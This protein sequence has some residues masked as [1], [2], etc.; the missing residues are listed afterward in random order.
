MKKNLLLFALMSMS[1]LTWSQIPTYKWVSGSQTS[2]ARSS[3]ILSGPGP[4][5]GAST[6]QDSQGN[7]WVFGGF[8]S[9]LT[10]TEGYYDDLW[11][12]DQTTSTWVWESG[13]MVTDKEVP[14][15]NNSLSFD[16]INDMVV[17]D[18]NPVDY[19]GSFTV[20][21]W[22][23]T[24]QNGTLIS[25]SPFVVTNNAGWNIA[26]QNDNQ[27]RINKFYDQEIGTFNT[28]T[29][30]D[31]Q[32]HH[33]ALAKVPEDENFISS[34]LSQREAF[35]VYVDGESIGS[36]EFGFSDDQDPDDNHTTIIGA[37]TTDYDTVFFKG[38]IDEVRFWDRVLSAGEIK[39]LHTIQ[40]SGNE[41]GLV[42][43]YPFNQGVANSASNNDNVLF[44]IQSDIDGNLSQDI[45]R[46]GVF[47]GE[48]TDVR[49][50]STALSE[51]EIKNYA[52]TTVVGSETNL[53]L[54]Y[55]FNVGTAGGDNTTETELPDLTGTNNGFYNNFDLQGEISNLSEDTLTVT[56]SIVL[57]ENNARAVVSADLNGDT[58][59]DVVTANYNP[60]SINVFINDLSGD[61]NTPTQHDVGS[62]AKE[63]A[64]GDLN[65]DTYDDLA[66]AAFGVTT[67]D[68]RVRLFFSD[69]LG[70]FSS[71]T[72]LSF[73][74]GSEPSE[75]RIADVNNDTFQ[76][77]VVLLVGE[78]R[79]EIHYGD[80]LG[81]F[82]T[83]YSFD[84]IGDH[85]NEGLLIEDFTND[86]YLDIATT[87]LLDGCNEIGF[88]ENDQTGEFSAGTFF[89]L[90]GCLGIREML[91]TDFNND[92]HKDIIFYDGN[93]IGSIFG[94][95]DGTF[96]E[97]DQ[98]FQ[99]F[100]DYYVSGFTLSDVNGDD[101][102]DIIINTDNQLIIFQGSN[103]GT[104][105]E[106][107]KLNINYASDD[108]ITTDIDKNGIADFVVCHD[109]DRI[110]LI[111]RETDYFNRA[112]NSRTI[113]F[114]GEDD[115]LVIPNLKIFD[116]NFTWEG[117]IKTEDNGPLFSFANQDETLSWGPGMFSLAIKYNRLAFMV[118]GFPDIQSHEEYNLT[119]G[120]WHH[121]AIVVELYTG[122]GEN[123][124]VRFFIDGIDVGV[125]FDYDFHAAIDNANGSFY[126]K[127]GYASNYFKNQ[128]DQIGIAPE[129]NWVEGVEFPENN[130][131]R[132]YAA[133]WSDENNLYV[134][135]GRGVDGIYNTLRSRSI[136]I[137][138][139][140]SVSGSSYTYFTTN[141]T[142][143][144]EET[145]GSGT[146]SG[147][148]ESGYSFNDASFGLY[149]L[150]YDVGDVTGPLLENFCTNP[151]FNGTDQFNFDF[152]LESPI[153]RSADSTAITFT[154]LSTL[155]VGGTTTITLDEGHWPKI[156]TASK[157][158][159][160]LSGS[161]TPNDPGNYGTL[162]VQDP[163]NS[164]PARYAMNG[165]V[166]SD[167]YVWIFG[168]AANIAPTEWYNDLWR[169]DPATN[170][171]MWVSGSSTTNSSAT[172]GSIGVGSTGNIPG[173]RSNHNIWTDSDG[174]IWIF[175]GYGFD[176]DGSIG[177]L[178]D[179]WKFDPQ[180][181]E[182]TWVNGDD[183][184]DAGGVY[185]TLDVYN[186]AN[187]PGARS[188][189]LQ[190]V[191]S[192]G[193]VWLFG[194]DGFDKFGIANNY[195]NDLWSYNPSL[196]QWAWHSGSD[197]A[198]STGSYNETGLASKDY[199]PGA[200][201]H[202]GGWVDQ[203]NDLWLF[204]GYKYNQLSTG[205]Y[206]DFWKYE[207]ESKEWTWISGY[208]TTA[209][210]NQFGVYDEEETGSK[211]HPGSRHGGLAWSDYEGNFWLLGGAEVGGTGN[212][213][214]NDLWKYEPKKD[215]W[216]YIKGST[217]LI[218]N[219]GVYGSK[220]IA[221]E[222]NDPKSRWHGASWTA[223][224]GKLWFFGGINHNPE[225][226]NIAWL[227]DLWYFDPST[228]AY[229]WIG[230][231]TTI[232]VAGV[233]GE[234]GDPSISHIPGARSS[235]AYWSDEEG[236]FWLFG[237]YESFEYNNDLWKFNPNTLEWTW[238]NGNN[239]QNSPSIYGELG[240]PDPNNSIGA[241]RYTDGRIDQEGNVW[242]FGGDGHDGQ[243]QRGLLND[244]WKYDPSTNIWT[245]MG[246]NT[247]RN[248]LGNYGTKYVAHP[249]NLPPPR[250]SHSSWIDDSGNLW[251]F[252]GYGDID[253]D[254]PIARGN[255]N[256]LW[257]YDVKTNL[258]TWM[259][260][261]DQIGDAGSFGAQGNFYETSVIPAKA[262]ALS[263]A[264]TDKSFWIFGGRNGPS[265]NDFWEIKFTPGLP[266][267]ES[268]QNI[269][270]DGFSFMSDEAWTREYQVQVDLNDDFSDPL[271]DGTSSNPES[272]IDALDPGTYY[273]YRVNAINEIGNSG[274]TDPLSILTL[275]ATPTFYSLDSAI[276]DLTSTQVS[277]D[278][279][280]TD[281]I[282]D[283][284]YLDV[285]QDPTFS[286]ATL[287][288][289][290]FDNKMIE[291]SQNQAIIDLNPGTK[292][293][294]RL[295]SYN[296]SGVSPYSQV[297]PFLTRP[298]APS[299]DPELV[300]SEVTQSSALVTWNEVPEIL[301]GYRITVSTLDDGLSDPNGYLPLYSNLN[302]A[303]TKTSLSV[304]G[305]N[306]G[307]NYYAYLVAINESGS[308]ELSGK[309][310]ILTTPASPVF[311]LETAINSITQNEITFNWESPDGF[312]N[313][314]YL[315]VS[316]DPSFVNTNLMLAGY[317]KGGIPFELIQSE[318][319]TTVGGL[320]PGQ[321]YFARIRA[322]ND[323][324]ISPNSNTLAF[325]TVPK[326]PI[327]GQV[328]NI[329]QTEASINWQSTV[330]TDVYL[331]DLNTS[332]AFSEDSAVFF[333][334]PLAVAFQVLDEL[335]PGTRYYL[336]VQSSNASGNS[337]D[338]D[339][340]DYGQ[341]NFITIPGTPDLSDV[342]YDQNQVIINWPDIEG[343]AT[344]E[345]DASNNFFLSFLTGFEAQS[346]TESEI[347]IDGLDAGEEYQV[348]VRAVNESGNSPNAQILDLLTLPGTP[349][350]RDASNSSSRVFTAN[351][352]AASG[353]DH[354]ILEVSVDDF[355]SFHYNEQLSAAN[356]IKVE[357]LT[358]G[359]T[360][361]Y[362]V[363]AGN[364]SGESP[365][366]E[367]ITVVAQNTAQSLSISSL[368]FNDEFG[369]QS[370][371]ALVTITFSGGAAEP[372]VTL[373][374]KETLSTRWSDWLPMERVS[375][376]EFTFTILPN[377]LDEIGV[378]FDI[379]ADDEVTLI[380]S[381]N[382]TIKRTF[383]E[384]ESE[385]LPELELGQWS[386]ISIPYILEDNL[387]QSIFNELGDL[388]YKKRWR[389]M[390]YL[391][392][393]YQDQGVG[394]TRID[395]G[396]GYWFNSLNEVSISVGAGQTN[397]TIPFE[398]SLIQGWNQIG[399][400]YNVTIDWDEVLDEN[401]LPVS[402]SRLI[403][404]D[405]SDKEFKESRTL[406]PFSGAFVF[407]DLDAV[408]DVSPIAG[409]TN[410]RI[411]QYEY[412]SAFEGQNWIKSLTLNWNGKS[413]EIAA[414][415]MHNQADH[416]KDP[417]D[418]LIVPRFEEYLEMYSLVDSY[419]Y[420]KFSHD[421]KPHSSEHVWVYDLESNH[422]SGLTELSWNPEIN[423][424]GYL[425]L[426]DETNGK[427][428]EMT[429][430]GSYSFGMNSSH[431]FS[432]H[433]SEDPGYVV[434][435]T[436][437]GL[438]DIYP[439]PVNNTA[440]ITL[441][442]PKH[443]E[444]Y[445]LSINL[446]NLNG[447][448]IKTLASGKYEPGIHVFELDIEE[449]NLKD[450]MYFYGVTFQ[451]MDFT[452]NQKKIIIKR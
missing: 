424:A 135:G 354:Y 91:S 306:Q 319:T 273:Y 25:F 6:F 309:I 366:S 420:P 297:V 58:Y 272:I 191:D 109:W 244:L 193:I 323:A 380:E 411:E 257:K 359:E 349:T 51:N 32:W 318:L 431:K 422:V 268:P 112:S 249:D 178:N 65:G 449:I 313:G 418:K 95:G 11:K 226:G 423:N 44:D 29:L 143:G 80:G 289:E 452:T 141:S 158:W 153:T 342:I 8:G 429:N 218:L 138:E 31:N 108:I 397:S 439:N 78:D 345:I 128:L 206:N 97:L 344:Y 238:V 407:A 188:A 147:S 194:G 61:L 171:W 66:V 361:K 401:N 404:Y 170:E 265:F 219:D 402:I 200:R 176:S 99:E 386:I 414:I 327:L 350:A 164:P 322:F 248:S 17:L 16:G 394:F 101:V 129:S 214:Y 27:I 360:Y 90:V 290:D 353:A 85:Y 88:H 28:N 328:N 279:E 227:N 190:W 75:V 251:I 243:S 180:T 413:K 39:S 379:Q 390:T 197:F 168:G 181:L 110:T 18:D 64:A 130:I 136:K 117:W 256:D 237:G 403:I 70:G 35:F 441:L 357:N 378:V 280:V 339:P 262:R 246:G 40:L 305:L 392:G 192:D 5:N 358:A 330:G 33:V 338:M 375:A 335:T 132:A 121:V 84:L 68:E 211:P 19:F 183:L 42:S 303:K 113:N 149:D 336:R 316:T 442:L 298:E 352:D 215:A 199:V 369:E 60:Q 395:L 36:E 254:G 172:Y 416:E 444:V 201:W 137:I 100:I 210:R 409:L 14:S 250:Y 67:G 343:A 98:V 440:Q 412:A 363:K 278:W 73:P 239:F 332:S 320:L 150:Y 13:K 160:I 155:G 355:Q 428:I 213:F 346:T 235:S 388:Q 127:L 204:G 50:W 103:D 287:I 144:P 299:F 334:F 377:M 242:V 310:N 348:R 34:S 245:W 408:V 427:I 224:D 77:I 285:S 315:E 148:P 15:Y 184:V 340:P 312:F 329:S 302:I 252:G 23:K 259:G 207:P 10:E 205:Y 325:T 89:P 24:D 221:S 54:A 307:T 255:M 434:I 189:G 151:T 203:N 4:R 430:V 72:D 276:N 275:P 69:G 59:P 175:G 79:I 351:W 229:T 134:F 241:R 283:G 22:F 295:Q 119:N 406:A 373:R 86:G 389:L 162:N 301:T 131:G 293:Y 177:H 7:Y 274:F 94:N 367:E 341:G 179:L 253:G 231:S 74:L 152:S 114:D 106:S 125:F 157:N 182:W 87:V 247:T 393:Q 57:S 198:G 56:P 236:N 83:S 374:H 173:P 426:V 261:S 163:T 269:R 111:K 368:E 45:Y 159:E 47:I 324:G 139:C 292:Y 333:N 300:V 286:D 126:A 107:S 202:S 133:E 337:G 2:R 266:F 225:I 433:Y 294:A 140:P 281:G 435:P 385:T 81:A 62:Y 282:L 187:I 71:T 331:M 438:G 232:D 102:D 308:S 398:M 304:T 38:Q 82:P 167:G 405:P 1:F 122:V 446:Y 9:D 55:D 432:I 311:N 362:R 270:Q 217:D 372:I 208:G 185:G 30:T 186:D 161:E 105:V 296:A 419:F 234:K 124:G 196:N 48:M 347:V 314:Y 421:I 326:A 288:H 3:L 317:G 43:Y 284:Y 63:L 53:D 145:N 166:D 443:N 174:Y 46:P 240:V 21:L 233:Y 365:Y 400:P 96:G 271:Y 291:V 52:K 92:G 384:T 370:T 445:D 222:L 49:V 223:Q 104:F 93:T 382:N 120:E 321:T 364:A 169:Y 415:G 260:G 216:T 123:D 264:T 450:G 410:A 277:I 41:N 436:R 220:G 212:G 118:E 381:N 399:N 165:A 376:S 116:N 258:W 20:E 391:D 263:F 195:L 387:V 209:K 425:W 267:V 448:L 383:T 26:I 146:I 76:D 142:F 396:K 230:G 12:Y 447:Q 356:P 37:T 451:N 154:W 156:V 417:F 371:S 115:H 228:E 437:L